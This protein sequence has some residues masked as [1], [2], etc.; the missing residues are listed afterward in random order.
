[1]M[2]LTK[3]KGQFSESA[4]DDEIVVMSLDSGTFFSLSETGRSIWELL[5]RHS[6]RA[7]LLTALALTYGQD[8]TAIAAELDEFL[9]SLGA[10]GLLVCT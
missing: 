6:D 4:I 7:E 1:M 9:A 8:E 10:A 2:T 5:D 3:A